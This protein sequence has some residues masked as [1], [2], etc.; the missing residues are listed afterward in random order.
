MTQPGDEEVLD[1]PTEWVAKH[2][3]TYVETDGKKGHL[4]QGMTTLLL[5]TR[6]RRSGRLRRTALIYGQDG[7]R[8]LLVASNGGSANH[9]AWYLNLSDD[10]G[11]EIQVG[12]DKFAA[13]ARTATAEEKPELWRKMAEIFPTYD[14]YQAKAGR[15]IPLVIVERV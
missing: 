4:Y 2:I 9:P 13:R 14:G 3:R 11:V 10:P 1:N 5:S 6:G 8:Y 7:D 15:D 12:P